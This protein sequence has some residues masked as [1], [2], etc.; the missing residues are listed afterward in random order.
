M[1]FRPRAADA[2]SVFRALCGVLVAVRPS[3]LVVCFGVISDWVDGPLARRFGP[4]PYGPRLDLEADSLLTL[5]TAIAALRRGAPP[6]ALL[7]PVARYAIAPMRPHLTP[8]ERKWD[9]ITGVGQM[10]VLTLA[11]A[12]TPFAWLVVPV[13]AARVATLA[14]QARGR[15][16]STSA[17]ARSSTNHSA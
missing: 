16:S 15:S 11:I 10:L 6:I 1:S 7:A 4:S 5:G 13:S 9:Q 3:V 12:R 17:P 14:A 8:D 2:F